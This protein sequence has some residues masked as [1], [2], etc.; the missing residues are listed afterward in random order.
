M[1]LAMSYQKKHAGLVLFDQVVNEEDF[2]D[3]LTEWS[4]SIAQPIE[5]VVRLRKAFICI[6]TCIV[7]ICNSPISSTYSNQ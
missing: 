7:V 5:P 6:L 1:A 2:L 4:D 3:F